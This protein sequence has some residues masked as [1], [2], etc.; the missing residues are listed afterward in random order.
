MKYIGKWIILFLSGLISCTA[1]DVVDSSGQE[2]EY[3]ELHVQTPA[4]GNRID[5]RASEEN[6]PAGV[7]VR[8]VAYQRQPGALN[9]PVDYSVTPPTAQ[10]TY[11][12]NADGTLTQCTVDANG[13]KTDGIPELFY[14]YKGTYDFYAVSP[15]RP[16]VLDGAKYQIK[17]LQRNEDV[18]TSIGTGMTVTV[19][20][21]TVTLETFVRKCARVVF[22][23]IPAA[24]TKIGLKKL[25]AKSVELSSMSAES[26]SIPAGK[27]EAIIPTAAS[28]VTFSNFIAVPSADD[29]KKLGLTQATNLVLPK[30]NASIGVRVTLDYQDE[31]DTAV[32]EKTLQA[33][34]DAMA[35]EAGKSYVV[36]LT[37]DNNSS[38]LNWTVSDW[39]TKVEETDDNMGGAVK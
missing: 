25:T 5:T 1:G 13:K 28:T 32:K 38:A 6:L 3:V 12:V 18:M 16:L 33:T 31:N 17:G 30:S 4:V 9:V 39:N 23:V 19:S 24:S 7:T 26:G 29:P 27:A 15:A 20:N 21:A 14:V 37:V 10:A 34:L 2:N 35:F 8:V 11:V 22:K 36:S